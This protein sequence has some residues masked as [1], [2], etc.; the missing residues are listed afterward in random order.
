MP[1]TRRRPILGALAV[2]MLCGISMRPAMAHPHMWIMF[3]AT[4]LYENGTFVG[5]EHKWTFDEFYSAMATEGLDKNNDG[6]Y[7]REELA[8]LTKVNME[9]L[10][11]FGYFTKPT[12][13]GAE[14]KVGEARDSWLEHKDG[15]LSLHFVLPFATPVLMDAKGLT[16]SVLDPTYYIAFEPAK[17]NAAKLSSGAPKECE[18]RIGVPP[19]AA[20]GEAT[21]LDTL[22]AQL[23]ALGVNIAKTVVVSCE[24][25]GQKP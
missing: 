6:I 22:Q 12:L 24:T 4:V 17:D 1:L 19:A 23:G 15:A 10:K 13:G 14:L 8:E 7:D 11:E 5:V 21:P 16:I 18:A 2:M 9:A 3:E 20:N 25:S